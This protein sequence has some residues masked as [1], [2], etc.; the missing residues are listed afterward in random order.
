M[1]R[2]KF[3]FYEPRK[4]LSSFVEIKSHLSM[5]FFQK[6]I[7]ADLISRHLISILSLCF[8]IK[9]YPWQR[10]VVHIMQHWN[11]NLSKNVRGSMTLCTF[12][13][14]TI[15]YGAYS[16]DGW[17]SVRNLIVENRA[18]QSSQS[19]SLILA[20]LSSAYKHS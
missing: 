12:K 4:S 14:P 11:C 7:F 1:H 3:T 5:Y 9:S 18:L 16:F 6:H 17:Y 8:S 10:I 20:A 13:R 15:F 19:K 2:K